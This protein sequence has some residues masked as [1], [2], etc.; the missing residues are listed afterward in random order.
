LQEQH[1]YRAEDFPGG[2]DDPYMNGL[3][4]FAKERQLAEMYAKHYGEGVI[5][6][7]I[8]MREYLERF[9]RHEHPYEGGPLTELEIPNTVVEELNQYPR[10]RHR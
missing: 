10:I 5:E 1:G 3:V 2:P 4:Y 7:Q 6:I 9:S 8:P